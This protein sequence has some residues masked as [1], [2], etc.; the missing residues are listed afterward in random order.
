MDL[1]D[2]LDRYTDDVYQARNAEAARR[3]IADPCLRHESGELISL[4]LDDNV[5]RV[6][7]FLAQY[8]AARFVNRHVLVDVEH[9]TTCYDIH[10]DNRVTISGMEIFRVVDGLIVETWNAK[11]G[12]GAW[13]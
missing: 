6:T 2:F 1:R 10:L 9:I 13:G 7:S 3:F 11:P 4:S 12:Q 8:P 5:K